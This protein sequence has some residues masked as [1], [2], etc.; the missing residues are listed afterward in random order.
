M[1]FEVGDIVVSK[2]GRDINQ[3]Y[4]VW[5]IKNDMLKLVNG[6]SRKIIKPKQKKQKHVE[7]VKK[8]ETLIENFEFRKKI[9]DAYLRKI[10][11]DN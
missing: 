1:K 9:N 11:N 10:L 6:K 8:A 4:I 2:K 5:E 3:K 7:F